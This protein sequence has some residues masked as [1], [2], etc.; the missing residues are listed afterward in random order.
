MKELEYIL[1]NADDFLKYLKS[2]FPLYHD[3]NVFLRDVHYGVMNYVEER[4]KRSLNYLD[5]ERLTFEVT[6]EFEK[7]G[8]FKKV[9]DRT[10][11]LKYPEFAL[12]RPVPAAK[13]TPQPAAAPAA[14][15]ASK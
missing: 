11:L 8:V 10:W 9:D 14:Q 2:K 13:P 6:K 12:P 1:N 3:S 5:A 15:G 4:L 7:K